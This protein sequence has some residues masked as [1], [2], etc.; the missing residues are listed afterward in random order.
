MKVQ[1]S[2]TTSTSSRPSAA[3]TPSTK[4][5]PPSRGNQLATRSPSDGFES[6][7][8]PSA[9]AQLT[10]ES[11]RTKPTPQPTPSPTPAPGTG[12]MSP[13]DIP[14]ADWTVFVNLNA[15]NNL[16]SFGKDDLNEMEAG[17]GSIQG[18]L[19][20]IALVDGGSGK[21][22]T[23]NWTNGTRLMYVTKDPNNSKKVVSREIQVDPNSDLGKLLAKGNGELDTGSPEVLRAALDYVQKNTQ[24]KHYMVDLWDHGNDW[25]GVSY[26]DHPGSSIDMPELQKALTG[27]PQ[28]IDILSA[29][30]CLMAT[31]EVADTAKAAG[32][33]F[34]VGSEEVEPGTGWNYTELLGRMNKLFASGTDVSAEQV[35]KAVQDS[36]AAGPMDNATM[37]VT[38]LSKLDGLNSKLNGFSDALVKAGGLQDKTVRA[39]YDKALRFDDADQMDLGDF[40]KRLAASTTNASLKTAANDLLAELAKTTTEKGAKGEAKFNAATGLTV[41]APRGSVDAQYKKTGSAWLDSHWNNVIKTYNSTRAV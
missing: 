21:D 37:S 32:V 26:D 25:R 5:L 35:A 3:S 27:L 24:S 31:A 19:N 22:A 13:K 16:E 40:A 9:S 4:A 18:K 34:L 2:P 1:T 23:N 6:K 7:A 39:A 8:T 30:A 17:G 20:M 33:D 38:D 14:A 28:K 12:P 15:D 11:R 10:G 29:D 36:Y 41:Y